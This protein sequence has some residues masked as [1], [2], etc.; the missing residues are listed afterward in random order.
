MLNIYV[1]SVSVVDYCINRGTPSD[2]HLSL[3]TICSATTTYPSFVWP[4]IVNEAHCSST[5]P[6]CFFVEGVGKKKNV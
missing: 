3:C 4:Y 5:D 6:Y 1:G 2:G